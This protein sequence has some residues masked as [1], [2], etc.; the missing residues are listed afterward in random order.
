MVYETPRSGKFSLA[1]LMSLEQAIEFVREDE[2]V[3]VMPKSIRLREKTL[4]QNQR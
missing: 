1:G 4:K 3:E 2:M